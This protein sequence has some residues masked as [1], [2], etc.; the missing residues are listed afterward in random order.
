MTDPETGKDQY[1]GVELAYPFAVE[2]YELALKRFEVMD[3]R[4]HTLL[5]LFVSISLALPVAIRAI[6]Y[7]FTSWWL[8]LAAMSFI[9]ATILGIYGRL[10]GTLK[11]IDPQQ[12]YQKF[13]HRGDWEFKKD[14]IYWAGEHYQAN[15]TQI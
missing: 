2:C 13:L 1:P 12:L 15:R 8:Y 11:V 5:T 6:G 14:F 7:S 10:T 9:G 3:A 4:I